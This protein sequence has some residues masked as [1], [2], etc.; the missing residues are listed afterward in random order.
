MSLEDFVLQMGFVTGSKIQKG[1]LGENRSF[2]TLITN[3][4][5]PPALK[6]K[7]TIGKQGSTP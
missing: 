2:A 4:L 3:S 1:R 5:V 7:P 6:I